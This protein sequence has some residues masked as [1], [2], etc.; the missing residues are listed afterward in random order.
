M[1]STWPRLKPTGFTLIEVVVVLAMVAILAMLA[2]PSMQAPFVRQQV[3][4]SSALINVAKSAVSGRWTTTLTLPQDNAEAGLPPPDKLVG[5]YVA[6]VSIEAGAV[7]VLFGNQAN[8][9]IKGKTLSFRPA[10]VD[11]APVVPIAW[12]CASAAVPEKMSVKGV[13]RTDVAAQFLPLNCRA[14]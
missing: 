14:S 11:G 6:S 3:V 13:N 8:G 2:L 9:A 1:P 5:N 10:V 7:H 4:D 12:I